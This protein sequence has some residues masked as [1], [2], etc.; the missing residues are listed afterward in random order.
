MLQPGGL[1]DISRG[2]SASDTPGTL[3]KTKCTLE[4][5]QS[6]APPAWRSFTTANLRS[7][8]PPGCGRFFRPVT[9]GVVAALLD[10]RLISG[11]PPGCNTPAKCCRRSRLSAIVHPNSQP[12]QT[13][14]FHIPQP[15]LSSINRNTSCDLA[16]FQCCVLAPLRGAEICLSG[17]RGC[18]RCAPQPPANFWQ[19][20]RAASYERSA[21]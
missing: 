21:R 4:G 15:S 3:L 20:F 19:P 13:Y 10:L 9:G 6:C 8:T 11:N 7:G 2:L 18:R 14:E 16:V 5:C 17:D 1:P 12:I